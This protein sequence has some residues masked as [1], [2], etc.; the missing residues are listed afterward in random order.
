MALRVGAPARFPDVRFIAE[1]PIPPIMCQ[2]CIELTSRAGTGYNITVAKCL[3]MCAGLPDSETPA[4]S[5]EVCP[6]CGH[7]HATVEFTLQHPDGA[8]RA[9]FRLR[10]GSDR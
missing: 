4:A 5:E 7:P 2:A 8:R 9:R 10:A 3:C 6:D 1:E